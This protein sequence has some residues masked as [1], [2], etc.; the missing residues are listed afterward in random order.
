M[1]K[2]LAI[3]VEANLY[4]YLQ[5]MI[6]NLIESGKKNRFLCHSQLNGVLFLWER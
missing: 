6:L 4:A 3:G 2:I 5:Q 1:D